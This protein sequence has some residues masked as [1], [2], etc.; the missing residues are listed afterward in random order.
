MTTVSRSQLMGGDNNSSRNYTKIF[1]HEFCTV[2]YIMYFI[3]TA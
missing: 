3:F 1:M 2:Q